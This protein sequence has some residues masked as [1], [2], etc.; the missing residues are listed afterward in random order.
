MLQSGQG[1]PLY[2][3]CALGPSF[4]ADR[5][6]K[7]PAELQ[8]Q[9]TKDRAA[10]VAGGKHGVALIMA[11]TFHTERIIH[12]KL[13]S[14]AKML[15]YCGIADLDAKPREA[16]SKPALKENMK[17]AIGDGASVEQV[18]DMCPDAK[19]RE[20]DLKAALKENMKKAIIMSAC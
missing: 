7:S 10:P 1:S 12:Q 15:M 8:Q 6:V 18:C 2:C 19:P 3:T 5:V 17:K 20:A 16:D 9:I 14:G 13:P 11:S 4:A